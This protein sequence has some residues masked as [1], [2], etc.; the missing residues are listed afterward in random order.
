MILWVPYVVKSCRSMNG[1]P[2]I[3]IK[4]P[5]EFFY[6]RVFRGLQARPP[7]TMIKG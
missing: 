3:Q 7:T 6:I 1:T 2:G 4:I 5:F